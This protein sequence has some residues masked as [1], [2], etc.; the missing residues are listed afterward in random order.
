MFEKK[1]EETIVIKNE[2][3]VYAVR[4]KSKM[5]DC[6]TSRIENS[7][8]YIIIENGQIKFIDT[9]YGA[10]SEFNFSNEVHVVSKEIFISGLK[11]AV[12]QKILEL[13]QLELVF[14]EMNLSECIGDT[15]QE[16]VSVLSKFKRALIGNGDTSN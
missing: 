9:L 10:K 12:K 4:L 13:K 8:P 2:K 3:M 15:I 16:N 1:V 7:N 6:S 5:D 14:A 11:T